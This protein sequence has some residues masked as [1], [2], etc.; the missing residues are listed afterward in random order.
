MKKNIFIILITI[1]FVVFCV[2]IVL[3]YVKNKEDNTSDVENEFNVNSNTKVEYFDKSISDL[4]NNTENNIEDF[5]MD[6]IIIKVNN[7]ELNVK[8]EDNTSSRA[9]AQKLKDGDIVVNAHDYENFEKV[10]NLGFTLP[11][12]DKNITTESGDLILYQGNQI[13]LYYDTNSWSFTKLGKVQNVSQN[14]LKDILGSGDVVLT[15]S[16]RK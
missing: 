14:E 10:G 1:V 15:F 12:N 8:L 4:N 6:E 13:T 2:A 3:L 5:N 11:T 9:F 7:R 16:L